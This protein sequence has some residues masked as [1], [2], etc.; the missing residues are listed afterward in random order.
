MHETI[1]PADRRVASSPLGGARTLRVLSIDGGGMRGYYAALYLGKLTQQFAK[2]R[3][4]SDLD[5]GRGFDLIAGTSTGGLLACALAMGVP[6]HAIA[7]LYQAHGPKIFRRR[8]PHTIWGLP[9]FLLGHRR[10]LM[11]GTNA[12]EEALTDLFKETTLGDVWRDRQIAL[13]IPAVNMSHHQAWVFKTPHTSNT[14]HRDDG[15][16]LVDVCL[17]TTAAPIFR[18]LAP[19]KTPECSDL[20]DYQVFADGG[21]WANTPVLVGMIDALDMA[22][23]DDRIEI[24]SLATSPPAAG[25]V[26]CVEACHRTIAGWR[27]GS[28]V[29]RVSLNSQQFAVNQMARLLSSHLSRP[30]AV[31]RFPHT[32]IPVDSVPHFDLD[33]TNKEALRAMAQQATADV[34]ATMSRTRDSSCETG[35]RLYALFH[36][37]PP[38]DIP[39]IRIPEPHPL[40]S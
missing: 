30:C 37:I 27:A 38:T 31:I 3:G 18:S 19:V 10:R 23:T 17:A 12:L 14:F 29:I 1:P 11:S 6:L 28:E 39:R 21:L 34:N 33:A 16:R 24:Y 8:V 5:L 25:E 22:S 20:D 15:Y 35:R 4:V 32:E 13:A 36:D 2:K 40:M 7:E 26:F 9:R